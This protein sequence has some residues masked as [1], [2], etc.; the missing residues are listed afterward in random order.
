MATEQKELVTN[1]AADVFADYKQVSMHE[2]IPAIFASVASA[3]T[4]AKC[5]PVGFNSTTEY[6]GAWVAPDPAS[7]EI[8]IDGSTGGTWFITV[9]GTSTGTFAY[10]AT[11]AVVTATLLG[12][13]YVATVDLTAGVYTIT[14]DAEAQITVVP[15]LTGDVASLTGGTTPV[16]TV[17][18]GASTYGLSTVVGFIWPDDVVLS[19]TEQVPGIVMSSGRIEY[20]DITPTV[21][22]GDVAALA[23]ELQAN[24]LSRGLII[25]NLEKTH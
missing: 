24:A 7:I 14:F 16:A 10:N 20:T 25:E 11:A 6:Y 9:D 2:R 22:A 21:D 18:A 23:A 8:D 3:T 4:L 5:T 19:L 15:V 13:G 1:S 17:T 12:M